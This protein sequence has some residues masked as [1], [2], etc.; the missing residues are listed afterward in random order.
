VAALNPMFGGMLSAHLALGQSIGVFAIAAY[1]LVN[2]AAL[3][4]PETKGRVLTAS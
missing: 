4:L 2:I 1:G 3:L